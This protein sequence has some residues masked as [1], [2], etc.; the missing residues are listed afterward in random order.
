MSHVTRFR[1]AFEVEVT[2]A[3]PCAARADLVADR[4]ADAAKYLDGV[5]V[6]DVAVAAE[7]QCVLC[8]PRPDDYIGPQP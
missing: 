1:I 6:L 4:M 8:R 5:T 2:A 7:C 3:P